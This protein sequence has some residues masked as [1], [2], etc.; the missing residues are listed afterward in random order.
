MSLSPDCAHGTSVAGIASGVA[1][2]AKLISIQV[3]SLVND[4][5]QCGAGAAP[6]ILALPS[7][8]MKGLDRVY[9]LHLM[10]TYHIAVANISAG[11]GRN[12]AT[13]DSKPIPARR[14]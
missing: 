10:G 9:G 1:K 13:C 12:T 7:D 11:L 8:Q 6:C 5:G 2:D 4:E 14:V 3:N